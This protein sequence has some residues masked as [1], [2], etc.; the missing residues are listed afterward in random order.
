MKGYNADI[1]LE[2]VIV[3]S[4]ND[5]VYPLKAVRALALHTQG[6]STANR[7]RGKPGI[8]D[9]YSAVEKVGWVQIDTLQVVNRSQ[10]IALWSRLG[11]YDMEHLDAL[12]FDGGSASPDSER[13]MF[14]Y[15]AHAA[16]II[17]LT[18]YRWLMPMMR[19]RANGRG[20][21]HRSWVADP[22]NAR[23]V[24]ATLERVRS[25]GPARPADFRTGKRAPG[26]WWNWDN[27]K[28]ALE[29]LYDVGTLAISNRVNFQRIYDVQERVIPEWVDR[30]EPTEEEGLKR[31]LEISLKALGAC[32]PVQVGDYFHGKRTEAKPLVESLVADGTFVRVNAKLADLETHELLVHR[33]NM[34]LLEMAADGEVRASRTTFL[35]PFDSLFWARGRDTGLWKFRQ[36]LE[37]YVPE[38]KRIWGYFCLPILY[39]DRLVGRFDPKV[40]RKAGVL[41]I[42]ALHLEPGV[43]PS[44]R[45]AASVARAMR[46][47]MK[48]HNATELVIECSDPIEFGENLEAAM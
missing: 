15:W 6:L 28:I 11:D 19:R 7:R 27:A 40:E 35:T 45:L 46:D 17:P 22:D 37:C 39:R 33:E 26:S 29:H 13:R 43:R 2:R 23:F 3:L 20:T 24:E 44:A 9:V 47:F 1:P 4:A 10:Y 5:I 25:E 32:E 31:M 30:R 21:W 38:P 42:K 16:C 36:T 18:S 48:F 34:P 41:R 8:E 14:E 12:L